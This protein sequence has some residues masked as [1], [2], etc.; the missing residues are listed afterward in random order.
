LK[1]TQDV[2]PLSQLGE[3]VTFNEPLAK[4]HGIMA[5]SLFL[6]KNLK[7]HLLIYLVITYFL[8]YLPNNMTYFLEHCKLI[9]SDWD[10]G[11]NPKTHL[12]FLINI[13]NIHK[14]ISVD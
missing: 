11:K 5:N 4:V 13:L 3:W 14:Y 9:P 12:N 7:N 8:T 6:C 10:H 2:S 1:T